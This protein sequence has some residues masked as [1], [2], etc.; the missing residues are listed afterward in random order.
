MARHRG[1]LRTVKP[2]ARGPHR[3]LAGGAYVTRFVVTSWVIKRM[4]EA[5]ALSCACGLSGPEN[6]QTDS[7]A[8]EDDKPLC[9]CIAHQ[10]GE[11]IIRTAVRVSQS[12]LR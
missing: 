12:W 1:V 2:D 5:P 8:Q 3:V 11:Q 10:T 6:V 4:F 9:P 7:P